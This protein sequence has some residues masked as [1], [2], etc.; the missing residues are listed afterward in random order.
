MVDTNFKECIPKLYKRNIE[1][2][3]LFFWIEGQKTIVSAITI[4]Q[5]I[6]GFMKY[7]GLTIDCYNPESAKAM[8][9][10]MKKEFY[11]SQRTVTE[12]TK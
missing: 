6:N 12:D 7:N 9:F 11:E 5:C 8:Y 2:I 1:M 10:Q 3:G 4:D